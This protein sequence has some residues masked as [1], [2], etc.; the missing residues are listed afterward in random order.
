MSYFGVVA[1][2]TGGDYI[3]RLY[4]VEYHANAALTLLHRLDSIC[5]GMDIDSA[6][7]GKGIEDVEPA[8]RSQMYRH[9]MDDIQRYHMQDVVTKMFDEEQGVGNIQM[10]KIVKP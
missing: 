2:L 3:V 1:E 8:D 7:V 6:C 5:A 10:M 9:L 4:D